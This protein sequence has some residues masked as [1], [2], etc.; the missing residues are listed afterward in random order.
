MQHSRHGGRAQYGPLAKAAVIAGTLAVAASGASIST[1]AFASTHV[2]PSSHSHHSA[3]AC[4]TARFHKPPITVTRN[5]NVPPTP[6][7]KAVRA[8]KHPRCRFD[9]IVFDITV[10]NPGYSIRFVKQ[11]IADP[12]GKIIKLPG[13]RFLLITLRPAQAHNNSGAS[14]VPRKVRV[15]RF[16]MLKSWVLAGDF[17]GVVSIGVG[18]RAKTTVRV[19]ELHHRLFIDFKY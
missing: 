7:V 6:V 12:S 4:P 3:A 18:L 19:G 17:E 5:F 16:P 13:K 14:T 1:A 15:L 9:R 11:V 2:R 10:R 8:A